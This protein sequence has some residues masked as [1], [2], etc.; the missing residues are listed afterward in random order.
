MKINFHYVD[1]YKLR[2]DEVVIVKYSNLNY[3]DD[4]KYFTTHVRFLSRTLD[5][6]IIQQEVK[7]E[8]KNNHHVLNQ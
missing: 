3:D 8:I 1:G 6:K 4:C 7:I 2:D 5:Y